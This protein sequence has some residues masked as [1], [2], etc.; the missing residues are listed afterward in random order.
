MSFGA[1]IRTHD[2]SA[3]LS[4]VLVGTVISV[5]GSF[6]LGL[7]SPLSTLPVAWMGTVLAAGGAALTF[8]IL[9]TGARGRRKAR[10]PLA[11]FVSIPVAVLGAT[12]LV[13]VKVAGHA[14]LE[15]FDILQ[16][17][18]GFDDLEPLP[19]PFEPPVEP[20]ANAVAA[21]VPEP[22][23]PEPVPE[24]EPE[25]VPEPAPEPL[26]APEPVPE[27]EPVAPAPR[28]KP[29]RQDLL[30]ARDPGPR[31][32]SVSG[33][34]VRLILSDNQRAKQCFVPLARVNLLPDRVDTQFSI[35]PDGT[36]E[37]FLITAPDVHRSGSDLERCLRRV[38][39]SLQF[40]ASEL[41]ARV[42]YPFILR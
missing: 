37:D 15:Q 24:P 6:V 3:D 21:P 28:P 19:P 16:N 17:E 41:G 33:E 12:G 35:Q 14:A 30:P 11:L 22:S 13:L 39:T 18:E 26:A 29:Q 23:A 9:W 36:A 5:L 4:W 27:P 10:A 1:P 7:I 32:R 38:V 8:G 40:P 2:P 34:A 42:D 20:P 31:P 25:P